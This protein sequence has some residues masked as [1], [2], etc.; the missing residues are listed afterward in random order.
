MQTFADLAESM[1]T[2][3]RR[4]DSVEMLAQGEQLLSQAKELLQA[5]QSIDAV[6]IPQV[7]LER[8]Q[9]WSLEGT[10]DI[11]VI[12]GHRNFRVSATYIIV[13]LLYLA[14]YTRQS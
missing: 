11:E 1:D 2:L 4:N 13:I 5:R 3:L 10:V 9:D 7:R 6:E 8:G 14:K 12:R